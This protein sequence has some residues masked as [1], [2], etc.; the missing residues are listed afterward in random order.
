LALATQ[1]VASVA[2][3]CAGGPPP[4]LLVD[5][6]LPYP[7][8]LLQVFGVVQHRRRPSRRGRRRQPRLKPPPGLLAGVLQKVRDAAGRLRRVRPRRLFGRLRDVRQRIAGLGIGREVNTSHLERLNGTLRDQQARL[9][10]RTRSGSRGESWLQWSLWLWRD[11]YNWVRPHES[12][13]GHT[14]AQAQGLAQRPWTVQE[15]ARYPVH[16]SDLQREDWD[17]RRE[18][19]QESALDRHKRRKTLPIS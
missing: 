8:A 2:L 9:R 15:Y 18:K 4:L 1:L 6:H 17:Q 14:P 3:C 19:A 5:D 13:A 16:V 12:L 7:S 11:L 10:R